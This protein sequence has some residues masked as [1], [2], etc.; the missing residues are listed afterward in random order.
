MKKIS[1]T[2]KENSQNPWLEQ[3]WKSEI[4]V[5][6]KRKY[7]K[8]S[9]NSFN[10]EWFSQNSRIKC[11]KKTYENVKS[12]VVSD[13]DDDDDDDDEDY[14][15]VDR[16]KKKSYVMRINIMEIVMKK[17]HLLITWLYLLTSVNYMTLSIDIY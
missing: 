5:V 16:N 10:I 12:D 7:C 1:R 14:N 6:C 15:D 13:N 8:F 4:G 17:W 2:R 11:W 9:K 3:R